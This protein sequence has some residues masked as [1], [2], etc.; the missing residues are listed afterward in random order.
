MRATAALLLTAVIRL[1]PAAQA[2]DNI[3]REGRSENIMLQQ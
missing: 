3:F 2:A 1:V